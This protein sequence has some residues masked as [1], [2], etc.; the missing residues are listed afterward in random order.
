MRAYSEYDEIC[1]EIIGSA[2]EV[3]RHL[4]PGLLESTYQTCLLYE[5][6]ARNLAVQSE[7]RLPVVYKGIRLDL[8]YRID[9][10]VEDKIVL[11]LKTVEYLTVVHCA[12]VLTYMRLGDHPVGFLL[13]FNVKLL[14][15]GIKRFVL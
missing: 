1:S 4:G 2:I 15:E 8:G 12:Q 6:E 9:V 14:K 11:E 3:H 7:L 10:L 5:L 13:N